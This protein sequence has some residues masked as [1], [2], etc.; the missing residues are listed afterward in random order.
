MSFEGRVKMGGGLACL[1]RNHLSCKPE[2]F[3][4]PT[5]PSLQLYTHLAIS[6]R[7]SRSHAETAAPFRLKSAPCLCFI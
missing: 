1:K 2:Y 4:V 7:D 3:F 6:V 5:H